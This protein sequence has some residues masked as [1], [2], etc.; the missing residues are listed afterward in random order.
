MG[1][2][3]PQGGVLSPLLWNLLVGGL[4]LEVGGSRTYIQAY[5]D[6]I[7][8]LFQGSDMSELHAEA[9]HCLETVGRWADD[10]DLVFSAGKSESIVFTWRRHWNLQPLLLGGHV[11]PRV[12]QVRYLGV[13]LDHKLNWMLHIS[14]RSTLALGVLARINRTLGYSWGMSPELIIWAYKALVLPVLEYGCVV[15]AGAL[16]RCRAVSEL[17]K[18]QRM[19]CCMALSAFPGTA[20]VV[21]VYIKNLIYSSLS[22]FYINLLNLFGINFL[23]NILVDYLY[24]I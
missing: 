21:M 9:S 5:A 20:T 2:G 13:T 16:Q 10:N 24:L 19:A 18:V 7:V 3:C 15:W 23:F 6:D 14:E 22:L 17:T 4:L 8:L 1:C 12:K 11:I